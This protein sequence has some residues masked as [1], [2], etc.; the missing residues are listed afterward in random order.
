MRLSTPTSA[1]LVGLLGLGLLPQSALADQHGFQGRVTNI[2]HGDLLRLTVIATCGEPSCPTLGDSLRIRLAE[3]VAPEA[4][5]PFGKEALMALEERLGGRIVDVVP[6][7][8]AEPQELMT[9][10][11]AHIFDGDVWINGWAVEEG[12]AWVDSDIVRTL[13]LYDLEASARESQIGLWEGVDPVEPWAWRE[14]H[15]EPL[16]VE[17]RP[18]LIPGP[19]G[20]PDAV[21]SEALMRAANEATRLLLR[22]LMQ[23]AVNS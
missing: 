5:Q 6:E 15:R 12:H 13:A 18:N 9:Y 22:A 23:H 19:A 2:L 3:V 17:R 7:E 1:L 10:Q 8:E 20:T 11:L 16:G 21:D 14:G 4:D